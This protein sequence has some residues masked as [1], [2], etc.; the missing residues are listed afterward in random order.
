MGKRDEKSLGQGWVQVRS[1]APVPELISGVWSVW[2][3]AERKWVEAPDLKISPDEAEEEESA[4]GAGE[5]LGSPASSI[6][7]ALPIDT[8]ANADSDASTAVG[9]GAPAS[10][11]LSSHP[12]SLPFSSG[13]VSA[14]ASSSTL[15]STTLPVGSS[16]QIFLLHEAGQDVHARLMHERVARVSPLPSRESSPSPPCSRST[17]WLTHSTHPSPLAPRPSGA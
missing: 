14:A 12:Q 15:V 3:S 7:K 13:S 8:N 4:D 2:N 16:S 1:L 11:S 5:R 17:T 10:H 6:P 9:S